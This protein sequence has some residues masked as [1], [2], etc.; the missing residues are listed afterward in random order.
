MVTAVGLT[1]HPLSGIDITGFEIPRIRDYAGR[2][3][4][5]PRA[6]ISNAGEMYSRPFSED[7]KVFPLPPA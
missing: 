3:V 5:D 2:D 6:V 7:A 4:P 1:W